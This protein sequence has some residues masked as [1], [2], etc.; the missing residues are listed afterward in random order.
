MSKKSIRVQ[1]K[2][3]EGVTQVK[4]L[5]K[6]P[7][8]TGLRKKADTGE[9]IP[10][11][12]IE[13]ITFEYAGKVVMSALWSGGISQNPYCS[14]KFEGGEK[15]ETITVTWKDNQGGTDS[16]ETQIKG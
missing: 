2:L 15:G 11:H 8:E 14:F 3:K 1:A 10:A 13:E 5:V 16:A 12:F 4:A 9:Y 6:H 7:M